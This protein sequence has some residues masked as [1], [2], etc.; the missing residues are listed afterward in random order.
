[1]QQ[2]SA[3][4]LGLFLLL[5]A[6]ALG[7]SVGN[8]LISFKQM[9]RAVVVKGLAEKEVEADV[10][11]WPIQY[12]RTGDD[13]TA[14]YEALERDQTLVEAFLKERG[15]TREELTIA[16]PAVI[17]KLSN[18]YGNAEERGYRYIA[19]QTLSL[20]TSQIAQ[21]RQAMAAL[22]VLGKQ[23]IVFKHDGYDVRTEYL[24]T[25]LNAIK[26]AMI[27]DATLGARA[28]AQKFAD[29][30]Q[31]KLGKI[32]SASQGQFT[33][34]DRDQNSPHIKTVRVVSTVEYY[35]ND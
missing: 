25:E 26:P 18:Q 28:A 2:S 22:S 32:K 27:Q 1:M 10:L 11:I 30:S 14:L 29:D 6:G 20:Y 12:T 3:F 17:D 4:I 35:L 34:K 5:S 15:F 21:A 23:G 9:D 8:G 19:S 16:A 31:S 13:L 7:M 24:F 33:I